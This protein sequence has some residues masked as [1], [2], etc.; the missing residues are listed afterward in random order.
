MPLNLLSVIAVYAALSKEM[1][2]P[3]RWP[4]KEL[5]FR[6]MFQLTDAG[7]LARAAEWSG[8]APGAADQT[9]NITNGDY[10][11]WEQLWS[12]IAVA[13]DMEMGPIQT[14]DLSRMMADKERLWQSMIEKYGLQST[15]FADA[16]NWAFGNYVLGNE[17]DVMS[18]T[19]KARK[20]GFHECQDSEARFVEQLKELRAEKFVP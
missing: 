6:K 9:F 5:A 11:R 14:V 17:W 12:K 2:L 13:F 7:L 3:L 19:L 4:G 10:F 18:D 16:A 1:G 8:T 20:A 15:A